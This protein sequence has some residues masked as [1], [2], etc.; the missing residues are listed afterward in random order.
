[1]MHVAQTLETIKYY[2]ESETHY[3]AD[4]HTAVGLCAARAVASSKYVVEFV[5]FVYIC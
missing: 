3:V 5:E 2:F 4:P 1:M